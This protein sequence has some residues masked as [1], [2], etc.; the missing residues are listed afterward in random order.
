MA[1]TRILED[2]NPLMKKN[3]AG[4]LV[5]GIDRCAAAA[6][7]IETAQQ[8]RGLAVSTIAVHGVMTG[9]L[10]PIHRYRLNHL[11][12]VVADGQ[13]VRWALNL[14][15]DVGLR[16]RVYGPSLTVE[17]LKR[18]APE[19]IPVYFY[20]STRFV[21]DLLCAR[22]QQIFP[23]LRIAGAEPSRFGQINAEAAD[24]IAA[25]IR[26]SGAR[27]VFVGLGCPRQEVWAY[28]FRNRLN[29]PILAVGA[30]FPFLAG[31]LRQA[32]QW[33]QD[34]GLEWL[35]R[36]CMEPRRLWRRYLLLSPA[37]IL[38]LLC[39]WLGFGFSI[40]GEKP[41]NEILYG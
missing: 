31:T 29:V 33:M 37:Y 20:G 35:F 27:I 38:L 23:G 16:E 14:L 5:D 28:E 30:A 13:P 39:Q 9:V 2:M 7:V 3:V 17:V 12:L 18:A 1:S 19:Q 25:R 40:D 34:S 10:D 21:L 22:F 26:E 8:G 6:I 24:S 15:H 36:L 4:I 41:L 11:D 32:P